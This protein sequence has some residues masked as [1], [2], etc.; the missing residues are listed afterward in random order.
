MWPSQPKNFY[1]RRFKSRFGPLTA[2]LNHIRVPKEAV[3]KV[4]QPKKVN[5]EPDYTSEA[6]ETDFD[7]E[8]ITASTFRA[9]SLDRLRDEPQNS[10]APQRYFAAPL[11]PRAAGLPP[12]RPVAVARPP[13][14]ERPKAVPA[15]DRPLPPKTAVR[16][17]PV[18]SRD[19][20][21]P[22]VNAE[23]TSLDVMVGNSA[24]TVQ[25]RANLYPKTAYLSNETATIDLI[26]RDTVFF[27]SPNTVHCLELVLELSGSLTNPTSYLSDSS[28][29][30]SIF[31]GAHVLFSTIHCLADYLKHGKLESYE[32]GDEQ[33]HLFRMPLGFAEGQGIVLR[34]ASKLRVVLEG[35]LPLV[36]SQGRRH[37]FFVRYHDEK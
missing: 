25:P 20:A 31:A 18:A 34:D 6:W 8:P 30:I 33:I 16:S 28:V 21:T 3:K 26:A 15:F 19:S 37:R 9:R 23:L 35:E 7:D 11:P 27:S 5:F 1:A 24:L 4:P 32:F 22:I 13:N 10:T 14:F 17:N 36:R 2:D 29:S 12:P